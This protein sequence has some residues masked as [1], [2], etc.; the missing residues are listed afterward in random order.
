[1]ESN[2]LLNVIIDTFIQFDKIKNE[3][4]LPAFEEAIKL[5]NESIDK[6]IKE[7]FT[8]TLFEKATDLFDQIK[9]IYNNQRRMDSLNEEN[10]QT[11][12]I[13]TLISVFETSIYSN[14][15]LFDKFMSYKSTINDKETESAFNV[16]YRKFI[17]NGMQQTEENSKRLKEIKIE[18]SH[19][20][21]DYEKNIIK[22]TDEFY[23][24]LDKE[25]D[26]KDFP[27]SIK[28]IAK[29]EAKKKD[30]EG[31]C[32]TLH[33]PSYRAIMMYCCNPEIRK[34]FYLKYNSKC[35]KTKNS[36]VDILKKIVSL[37]KEKAIL[38]GYS[39]Y[40]EYVLSN[41]M[42]KSEQ[43]V[44]DF[45]KSIYDK[46]IPKAKEEYETLL[47]FA[48][49]N[50]TNRTI[51]KLEPW[52]LSYYSEKQKKS[53]FGID[54]ETL[55]SHFPL[56]KVFDV[57]FSLLKELYDI[58]VNEDK[59]VKLYH[60]DIIIFNV[61]SNDK[62]I[63]YLYY[64]LFPRKSKTMGGWVYPLKP[65][66][67]NEIPFVGIMANIQK[68]SEGS[69]A[70]AF[71]SLR[72]AETIFHETG[73]AMHILLSEA[74]YKTLTGIN[75]LWD[76]VEVPSQ[77]MEN[78]IYEKYILT[79]FD[80]NDELIVTVQ[81]MKNYLI[82]IGTLRQLNFSSVDMKLHAKDFDLECDI[83]QFEKKIMIEVMTKPEGISSLTAFSHLFNATYDYSCGYYSYMWAEVFALDG[84]DEFRKGNIKEVGK[85]YRECI[86]SKGSSEDPEILFERFKGR[87][88]SIEPFLKDKGLL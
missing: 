49:Q 29:E 76:F 17:E 25:E 83:E 68:N 67:I 15:A 20:I 4:F 45:Q 48:I 40:N 60:N 26:T 81:K 80:F 84:Y 57:L 50:E 85:R 23:M 35:Y 21:S 28:K 51:D 74:K 5:A 70:Q 27:E 47:Q 82:A 18:M 1:M 2:C 30:K 58:D 9:I 69:G 22:D 75:V 46:V 14:K 3:M 37:R 52:D 79:K 16:H 44:F 43:N 86:L 7:E 61:K 8:I 38:L 11:E 73:H 53:I 59:T 41:R 62:I 78:F 63:G 64:D 24:I 87:K 72:E 10:L 56:N 19:L 33:F 54:T 42:A 12:K 71:L 13:N 77:L 65:K 39:S 31:Y 66:V 36:N 6:L 55:R 88:Y 32:F 34:T